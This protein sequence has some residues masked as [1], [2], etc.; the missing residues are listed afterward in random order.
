MRVVLQFCFVSSLLAGLAFVPSVVWAQAGPPNSDLLGEFIS[1]H[2]APAG[3]PDVPLVPPAVKYT[4]PEV[5]PEAPKVFDFPG[6]EINFLEGAT[7]AAISDRLSISPYSVS[8]QSDDEAGL[9]PR[10]NAIPIPV[11]ALEAFLPFSVSATSDGNVAGTANQQSDHLTIITGFHGT[12]T[13]TTAFEGTIPEIA[14][15]PATEP[16]LAAAILPA[17]Y[18]VYEPGKPNV[19]SDYVDIQ[20]SIQV[21]FISSDDPAVYANLPAAHGFVLED[22]QIGGGVTYSLGFASDTNVPEPTSITLLCIGV[23]SAG[24]LRG[25]YRGR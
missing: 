1:D 18:D 23:F 10:T 14:P 9:P 24:L 5:T 21:R 20:T 22:F 13:G 7:T 6:R 4:I 11:S 15:D 17:S 16:G 8:V 25:R 3:A 19:V 2:N 12:G